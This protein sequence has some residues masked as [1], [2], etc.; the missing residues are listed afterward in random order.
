MPPE[1]LTVVMP[2]GRTFG[3]ADL[4]T[5]MQWL[6][7]GRVPDAAMI[8]DEATGQQRPASSYRASG[9]QSANPFA[10]PAGM[11]QQ[12]DS[13]STLIPYR[14]PQALT[15]YYLGVFS[16][17]ACIPLLGIA[18]VVMAIFA[19]ICGVRGLRLA[20]ENPQSRGRVHAWIGIVGGSI[21]ALVGI[22]M[23]IFSIIG[24]IA[25]IMDK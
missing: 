20:K 13:L 22:P 15:A 23:Q 8:R 21:F 7:E 5:I 24:V 4:A 19:V 9:P 17:S 12:D 18:G 6:S 14:N 25:A 16:I 10:S 11:P 2:D 1:Q 3:P